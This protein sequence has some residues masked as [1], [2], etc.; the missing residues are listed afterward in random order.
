MYSGANIEKSSILGK[1]DF[2]SGFVPLCP[3]YALRAEYKSKG[4]LKGGLM[5]QN[6]P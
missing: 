3:D 2:D 4:E 5:H 6:N 1:T